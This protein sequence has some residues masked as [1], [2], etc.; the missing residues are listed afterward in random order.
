MYVQAEDKALPVQSLLVEKEE[1]GVI[2]TDVFSCNGLT[3]AQRYITPAWSELLG[4]LAL[5]TPSL[6]AVMPVTIKDV[7]FYGFGSLIVPVQS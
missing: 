7:D 5:N 3:G 2:N 1:H 4:I 6:L